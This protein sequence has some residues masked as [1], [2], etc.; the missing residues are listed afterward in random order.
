VNAVDETVASNSE[1]S[2]GAQRPPF[3]DS[4][5]AQA[6]SQGSSI[7]TW[8]LTRLRTFLGDPPVEFSVRDRAL[9]GPSDVPAVARV[10]FANRRTLMAILSD[11]PLRFGDAYS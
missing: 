4:A 8:L 7:D 3:G 9:V 2:A 11:P 6:L 5:E 10:T 1:R